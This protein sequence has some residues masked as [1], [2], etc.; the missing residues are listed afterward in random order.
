[1]SKSKGNV[2]DPLEVMDSCSLEQLLQKLYDSNLQESE[3]KESVVEKK[4][5]FPDGIPECGTDAL[6]YTLMSYM[7]Q[8]SINL[9]VKRAEGYRMFCNKLWNVMKFAIEK[10]PE[11]FQPVEKFEKIHENLA[12][13]DKWILTRLNKLIQQTNQNFEEYKLGEMV[14]GLYD[15]LKNELADVYIEAIKPVMKSSPPE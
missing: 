9:D 4:K 1:M 13:S 15:F 3:I 2:I 11:G 6:R 8:S 7:I 12:L 10:F 5:K 14:M